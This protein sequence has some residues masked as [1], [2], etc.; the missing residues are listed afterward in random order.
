MRQRS[1]HDAPL[2]IFSFVT[3]NLTDSKLKH[4]CILVSFLS[5]M[6]FGRNELRIS[7]ASDKVLGLYVVNQSAFGGETRFVGILGM[8]DILIFT[9]TWSCNIS[10]VRTFIHKISIW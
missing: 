4:S 9:S 5:L 10:I 8:C 7:Y 1:T 6:V 2:L 3:I